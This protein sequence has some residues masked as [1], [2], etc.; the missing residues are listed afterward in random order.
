MSRGDRVIAANVELQS[1]HRL[2][3]PIVMT[4]VPGRVRAQLSEPATSLASKI[5]LE[6]ILPL[7]APLSPKLRKS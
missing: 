4:R 5:P 6:A 1:R 3:R 2:N 7:A